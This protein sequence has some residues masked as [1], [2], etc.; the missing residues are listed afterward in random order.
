MPDNQVP[1]IE[2]HQMIWAGMDWICA[3]CRENLPINAQYERC[4]ALVKLRADQELESQQARKEM[5]AGRIW[6]SRPGLPEKYPLNLSKQ[7]S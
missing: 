4:D 6:I 3:V 7:T 5:L 1:K 2:R